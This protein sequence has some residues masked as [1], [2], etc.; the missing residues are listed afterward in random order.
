MRIEAVGEWRWH[1]L[2]VEPEP[3]ALD[4]LLAA[5]DGHV[6]VQP[7]VL[8]PDGELRWF[9]EWPDY[10]DVDAI[11]AAAPRRV[12]P[13]RAASFHGALIRADALERAGPP[14]GDRFGVELT[15]RVLRHGPGVLV[16]SAGARLTREPE[17]LS[18]AD[19]L[20]AA[21]S[22]AAWTPRE[23]FDRHVQ[24]LAGVLGR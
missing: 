10:G 21:R 1:L 7:R 16:P 11:V 9:P 20:R 14:L 5:A 12:L 13:L 19:Q 4:A 15:A 17:P 2:D 22:R 3:G 23:R 6:L 18:L 24:A 8:G